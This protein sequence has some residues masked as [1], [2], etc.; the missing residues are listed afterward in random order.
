MPLNM[1]TLGQPTMG[2]QSG[3]GTEPQFQVE[4]Y[5]PEPEEPEDENELAENEQVRQQEK[6]LHRVNIAERI[7]DVNPGV[8]LGGRVETVVRHPVYHSVA[9]LF[10]RPV[11]LHFEEPEAN[12]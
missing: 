5:V 9:N 3:Q 4:P 10:F 11:D 12:Q 2:A 7:D 8:Y 6:A 1:Q